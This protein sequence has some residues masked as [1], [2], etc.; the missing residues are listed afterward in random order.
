MINGNI[1]EFIDKLWSGEELI[2]THNG[3]KYF[4]QG[5]V[6]ENGQYRFELQQWEPEG[7]MLWYVEGLNN[8]S[9]FDMFLKQ[10]LFGGK[11]FWE[12]EQDITWVDY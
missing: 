3:K 5:Y 6:L 4:S 12:A 9:S 8:Q 10:H 2:Y 7:K 1:D 11:T